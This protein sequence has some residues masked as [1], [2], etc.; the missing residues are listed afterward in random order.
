[1]I[2]P[3]RAGAQRAALLFAAAVGWLTLGACHADPESTV[4]LVRGRAI[5]FAQ[6]RQFADG[7]GTVLAP[8]GDSVQVLRT[9]LQDI[10][11][12]E[13]LLV[14]AR[15]RRYQ[16]GDVV[17]RRLELGLRQKVVEK[18]ITETI[19]EKLST[20]QEMLRE[21]YA[22]SKWSRV[23]QLEQVSVDTEEE[24]L[25]VLARARGGQPFAELGAA[26]ADAGELSADQAAGWF[27][28]AD[29]DG[30]PVEVADALFDLDRGAIAGPFEVDET[31][32]VYRVADSAPAP[33]SYLVSFALSE[34]KRES[35]RRWSGLTD[36]LLAARPL[37]FDD[38]GI[39]LLIARRPQQRLQPILLQPGEADVP[40]CRFTGG[41][42]TVRDFADV[43]NQYRLFHKVDFDAAGISGYTRQRL[44]VQALTYA[45]AVEAGF[46]RKPDIVTW[47][48]A[49]EDVLVVEELRRQEVTGPATADSAA[50]RAFYES[51]PRSFTVPATYEVVE[52]LVPTR[53]QAEALLA[54]L[55]A[56]E[57]MEQLAADHS[58]RR[59][60]NRGRFAFRD[61]AS[62]RQSLGTLYDS[63]LVADTGQVRG[64]VAL[65]EGYAIFRVVAIAPAH[66]QPYSEAHTRAAWFASRQEEDRLFGQLVTDLRARY[67]DDVVVYEDRFRALAQ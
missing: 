2:V 27:G 55:R 62:V 64:P 58:T 17:A 39:Q 33:D 31:Y 29:L 8:A 40:L 1:M 52:I 36:S 14:E 19:L 47:R 5:T 12:R 20:D 48:Q 9:Y 45:V 65:A 10:I 34:S 6:V 53:D 7:V 43:Y 3:P 59:V 32:R 4:A 13:L 26:H 37:A 57:D 66:L 30:M 28:V 18:Y 46:D 41:V 63:I 60:A 49:K 38:A 16:H 24:A 25:D 50:A 21:R 56:G 44:V 35:A 23:L 42:I 51:H 67:A 11:D 61:V 15:Q 22:A 54:R